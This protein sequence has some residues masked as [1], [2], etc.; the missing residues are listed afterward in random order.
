MW[1][2]DSPSAHVTV[3]ICGSRGWISWRWRSGRSHARTSGFES[4]ADWRDHGSIGDETLREIF[5]SL[6]REASQHANLA[7]AL[8][9]LAG[10]FVSE[11]QAFGDGALL[12]AGSRSRWVLTWRF[13]G[14]RASCFD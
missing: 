4:G 6:V 11:M 10:R 8:D 12:E 13:S 9:E 5:Q 1:A 7:A 14:G 3:G 2:E